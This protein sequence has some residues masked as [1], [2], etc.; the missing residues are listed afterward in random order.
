VD[1]SNEEVVLE[2]P[3]YWEVNDWSPDSRKLL[4]IFR[5]AIT[6]QYGRGDLIEFDLVAAKEN[7]ARAL[8]EP[9]LPRNSASRPPRDWSKPSSTALDSLITPLTL[10]DPGSFIDARYSPDGRQIATT[11]YHHPQQPGSDFNPKDFELGVLDVASRRLRTIAKYPEGIR[12]PICWS[13]DGKEILFSRHLPAGDQREKL[14]DG[15]GIWAIHPD[16]S[17]TRFL[18]TGWDPDWR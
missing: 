17:G 10:G 5:P 2:R 9:S 3:G 13:P 1:G 11:V 4:L 12:G 8:G 16:G 18:T 14:P 15:L 7:K 6:W